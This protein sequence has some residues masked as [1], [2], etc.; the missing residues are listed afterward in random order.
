[1]HPNRTIPT[2]PF[3]TSQQH[4]PTLQHS[5]VW[6]FARGDQDWTCKL[7]STSMPM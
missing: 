7:T 1:L 4:H 2:I 6:Q 3:L 5:H